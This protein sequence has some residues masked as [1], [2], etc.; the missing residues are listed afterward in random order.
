MLWR[1]MRSSTASALIYGLIFAATGV[2]LPFAGLWF[3]SR[4]LTGSEIAVI[5][6]APML[7]R[8]VT[9]PMVAVWADGFQ[10]RRTALAWL[11]LVAAI[12]YGACM[13]VEGFGLWL[14]LWFVASTAAASL[15]PLSD[16]LTLKLARKDGFAFSIPRGVGSVTFII[17]NVAMG[18]LLR[19]GE[20]DVIL[21]WVV[22]VSLLLV[23]AALLAPREPVHEAVTQARPARLAGLGQLIS[24]R[25]FMTAVTAV[26]LI[27][28]SHAF[29]YGF[30][31][32]AWR[33]QG[34][35]TRDV[36]LLWGFS[37]AVEVGLM[38]GLEPWRR[39]RG[40]GPMPMLILGGGAAIVRWTALAM[41]PPLALLWPLQALHAL[42]FAAVFLAAMQLVERLAPASQATAAQMVYSSLS[43][44]I[45]IGLAT[46]VSGPLYDDYGVGGYLAMSVLAALGLG[47]AFTIRRNLKPE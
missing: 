12:A 8:A 43:A 45:L 27:Q 4:G 24:D 39:R 15:I 19:S 30:S 31:A 37:V 9:G 1:A 28:A 42:S 46:V 7:A 22:G 25:P 14:T 26:S 36:G 44:G 6:A 17:A 3:E 47:L 41:G 35:A 11:A 33:E 16:A 23:M 21:L 18:L 2:S 13:V 32:I 10:L 40:I 5:L 29:Y 38:W 34:V 20:Q